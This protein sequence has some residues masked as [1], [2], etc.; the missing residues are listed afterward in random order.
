MNPD[1]T[2]ES[3]Q[4]SY[5]LNASFQRI[6]LNEG[7]SSGEAHSG[8]QHPNYYPEQQGFQPQGYPQTAPIVAQ[9]APIDLSPFVSD[10]SGAIA[11]ALKSNPSPGGGSGPREERNHAAKP[12][13]YNGNRAMYDNFRRSAE[14][15]AAG[16]NSDRGKILATLSFL[17]EGDAAQWCRN[18]TE[19]RMTDVQAN[20]VSWAAFLAAL[21]KQFRNPREAE[22]ARKQLFSLKMGEQVATTFFLKVDELRTKGELTDPAYHDRL[23]VEHLQRHMN[24]ALV[25]SVANAYEAKKK[26]TIETLT[27]LKD[28]LQLSP[29]ELRKKEAAIDVPI[30]YQD[31]RDLAI[32]QDPHV[33]RF[34]TGGNNKHDHDRD[35]DR[36]RPFRNYTPTAYHLP[37]PTVASTVTTTTTAAPAGGS[38]TTST[39]SV[40]E[41]E[42][43]VRPMD[44]DRAR[45]RKGGLCYTCNKPGHRSWNCP[46]NPQRITVRELDE[47]EGELSLDEGEEEGSETS[48]AP[49]EEKED[50]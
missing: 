26:S 8:S 18:F 17:T 41:R 16:I 45:H 48:D 13:K 44:V 25:L 43:D 20:K 5:D 2:S 4:G 27:V 34:G 39:P 9:I 47:F 7:G 19:K 49:E 15:Y 3:S 31:F 40:A 46:S 38:T 21:D 33:R 42:P 10:L 36:S 28:I 22:N 30:S 23:I 24:P 11:Q 1:G 14:L 32:Q 12:D 6:N 37:A 50:F 35:R 29:E